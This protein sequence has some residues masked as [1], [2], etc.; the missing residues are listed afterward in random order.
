[1]ADFDLTI[2]SGEPVYACFQTKKLAISECLIRFPDGVRKYLTLNAIP[3]LD[4]KGDVDGAFYIWIDYTDLHDK[5]EAVKK[6]E[7]RVDRIIQENPFP[8]FTIDLDL[9]V[10]IVQPGIP[11][12][13]R[14]IPMERAVIP[15]DEGLQISQKQ[16]RDG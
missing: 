3:I 15:F 8:L 12:N 6:M 1:M 7:Q 16:G 2:L 5:I 9:N 11:R 13:S 14:V 4:K 10:K